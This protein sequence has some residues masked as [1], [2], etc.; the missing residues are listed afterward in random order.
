MLLV[1]D[2]QSQEVASSQL[3]LVLHIVAMRTLAALLLHE[4][5]FE[6]LQVSV[7][8]YE[9]IAELVWVSSQLSTC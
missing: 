6:P 4:E 8:H 7:E 9:V 2:Q 3:V 5:R 1:L